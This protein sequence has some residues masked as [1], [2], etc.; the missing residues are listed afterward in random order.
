MAGSSHRSATRSAVLRTALL[1]LLAEGESHGYDLVP[2]LG[3]FGITPDMAG[4]YRTLRSMDGRGELRS[5]WDSSSQ[6]PPRRIYRITEEGRRLLQRAVAGMEAQNIT[7]DRLLA[8]CRH[9][10]LSPSGGGPS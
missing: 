10:G 8:H 7:I 4:V 1:A 9:T 3:A 2:R 6:G 5:V